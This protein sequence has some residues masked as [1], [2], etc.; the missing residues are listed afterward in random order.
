MTYSGHQQVDGDK[1]KKQCSGKAKLCATNCD[2]KVVPKIDINVG[3]EGPV[4]VTRK[5]P[6]GV[7]SSK[8][9]M[10]T[11][12][13]DGIKPNLKFLEDLQAF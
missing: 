12:F 2:G 13:L 10:G 4:Y 6:T 8:Q 1:T 3:F 11:F 9:L 5:K 7:S